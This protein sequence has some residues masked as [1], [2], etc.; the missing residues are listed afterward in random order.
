[1]VGSFAVRERVRSEWQ[2]LEVCWGE[3]TDRQD[4]GMAGEGEE[5]ERA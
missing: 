5:V 3:T 4:S 1:M 2:D